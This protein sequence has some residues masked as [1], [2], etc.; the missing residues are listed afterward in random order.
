MIQLSVQTDRWWT[1]TTGTHAADGDKLP[2]KTHYTFDP[3]FIGAIKADRPCK[4][5]QVLVVTHRRRSRSAWRWQRYIV[6]PRHMRHA[7]TLSLGWD[8]GC[9]SL[10]T[11]Q[12]KFRNFQWTTV[13]TSRIMIMYYCSSCLEAKKHIN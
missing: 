3:S 5:S 2:H 4:W 9:L 11:R 7:R 6:S 8:R 1:T 13:R 12:N 10:I